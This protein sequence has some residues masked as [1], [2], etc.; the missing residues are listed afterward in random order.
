MS[1]GCLCKLPEPLPVV[2]TVLCSPSP[3]LTTLKVVHGGSTQLCSS[4]SPWHFERG[5]SWW[6]SCV[7]TP[8]RGCCRAAPYADMPAWASPA[9]AV[10]HR[11][12]AMQHSVRHWSPGQK[13][14]YDPLLFQFLE[15]NWPTV[16]HIFGRQSFCSS[17]P[18]L[19]FW[20]SPNLVH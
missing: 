15:W 9:L 16:L 11:V 7:R 1:V 17:C 4:I 18:Q 20:A 19:C 2:L 13:T 10:P 6:G 12:S 8:P 14:M 3:T 5:F